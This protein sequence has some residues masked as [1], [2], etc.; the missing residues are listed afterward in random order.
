MCIRTN[1]VTH[2]YFVDVEMKLQCSWMTLEKIA[3]PVVCSVFVI[4][5]SISFM[6][7]ICS[8]ELVVIFH[9]NELQAGAED[10]HT[11]CSPAFQFLVSF[12]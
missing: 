7:F 9:L 10:K 5:P 1:R 8:H 3:V 12:C 2:L 4:N 6:F 11:T